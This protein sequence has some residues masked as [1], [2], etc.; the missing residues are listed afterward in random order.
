VASHRPQT[1]PASAV[2][3]FCLALVVAIVPGAAAQ[4]RSSAATTTPGPWPFTVSAAE[5]T[6][7]EPPGPAPAQSVRAACRQA[8]ANTSCSFAALVNAC[9][10]NGVDAESCSVQASA[11]TGQPRGWLPTRLRAQARAQPQ[12][13]SSAAE[14]PG[15]AVGAAA[16]D[17]AAANAAPAT[18]DSNDDDEAGGVQGS[19]ANWLVS[20][21]LISPLC[22][23]G[24]SLL[25]TAASGAGGLLAAP[26]PA[27]LA[28]CAR[29]GAASVPAGVDGFAYDIHID[30]GL[31]G[32]SSRSVAKWLQ[33]LTSTVWTLVIYFTSALFVFLEFAFGLDFVGDPA[34]MGQLQPQL[35]ALQSQVTR[36]LLGALACVFAVWLAITASQRRGREAVI[37]AIETFCA[38]VAVLLVLSNPLATI[39]FVAQHVD[40]FALGLVSTIS[41]SP[42]SATDP[43]ASQQTYVSGLQDAVKVTL[44]APFSLLE[45]GDARWGSDP[46]Q[47]SPKLKAAA[48]RL[49]AGDDQRGAIED[50][51]TNAQLFLAFPA[52]GPQRN[53]INKDDPPSLFRVLCDNDDDHCR[54][55]FKDQARARTE[56]STFPRIATV[57]MLL[58]GLAP[59][60]L[61]LAVI[62]AELLG[63]GVMTLIRLIQLAF[64][65]PVVYFGRAGRARMRDYARSML[66]ALFAKLAY[67]VL[68]TLALDV[69]RILAMLDAVGFWLQFFL[70]A[71]AMAMIL[72]HRHTLWG[73]ARMGHGDWGDRAI[74]VSRRGRQ[75]ITRHAQRAV[76]PRQARSPRVQPPRISGAAARRPG[77]A[78]HRPDPRR[79]IRPASVG[80]LGAAGRGRLGARVAANAPVAAGVAAVVAPVAGAAVGA[81][82]TRLRNV[83]RRGS[84]L[85]ADRRQT[86]TLGQARER[87]ARLYVRTRARA[88]VLGAEPARREAGQAREQARRRSRALYEVSRELQGARGPA[89]QR[90]RRRQ[91]SLTRRL[92][93]SNAA[94]AHS[95]TRS[96]AAQQAARVDDPAARVPAALGARANRFLDDQASRRR[97][98]PARPPD[99]D[100]SS[101]RRR[102]Y[103][104]LAAVLGT[105]PAAYDQASPTRQ[106]Q[107]RAAID[108]EL[109]RR[110]ISPRSPDA[111]T[112]RG[113]R[114][115]SP[116]WSSHEGP[117]P[118]VAV[119]DAGQRRHR[120][121]SRPR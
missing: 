116:R 81:L 72:R 12:P 98:K 54:G 119:A 94:V 17:A 36:P 58:V 23:A 46:A 83:R 89:R 63:A 114:A 41:I 111:G 76:R 107:M 90:L 47:L 5:L 27:V 120:R 97:G 121:R 7:D 95:R 21:G 25:S 93:A 40:R 37:G 103:R 109:R 70:I 106:L 110:T 78:H 32:M 79:T 50:A 19:S 87:Q 64:I 30:T 38:L 22:H 118:R 67:A 53:A 61:L 80:S 20:N 100:A 99:R 91:V 57:A 35:A 33:M 8:D 65:A 24:T 60:W 26:D 71:I 43:Q 74:L 92:D 28:N 82:A 31:A 75:R 45:F 112:G 49:A 105:A 42:G 4:V 104:A 39:G 77:G 108:R 9:H 48:L 44:S 69:F 101:A 85:P 1:R 14:Q 96:M 29:S 113:D 59:T 66:G 62:V 86:E 52:N 84:S 51:T 16:A 34:L 56:S 10:A 6:G 3:A 18:G 115:G 102:D 73:V 13:A 15:A 68:L 55:E 2:A 88:A 117:A 11:L